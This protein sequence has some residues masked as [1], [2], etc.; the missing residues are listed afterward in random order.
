MYGLL[1]DLRQAFRQLRLSPGFAALAVITLAL[2]IGANTTMFTVAEDVLL[3]PLPYADA[4]RLTV[5]NPSTET[6]QQT[7]SWLN[8]RD[9]RD[10]A[11][12]SFSQVA[13]FSEDV[14]VVESHAT[15]SAPT[16][17][18]QGEVPPTSVVSPNVS[19]NI[20][21]MLGVRPLLGRAFTQQEGE[22]NG[23]K[24]VLLSEGLWREAFHANPA[25]IGETIRVNN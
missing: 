14:G 9:V 7:T 16:S 11:T 23:P 15:A 22:A 13:I 17:A 24:V 2:A 18:V 6:R 8:Y 5:I 19:P 21:S 4:G 3:R 10:Q 1:Q 25:I 20:F 12:G